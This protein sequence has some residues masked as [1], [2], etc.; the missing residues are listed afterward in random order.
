MMDVPLREAE[1]GTEG[2]NLIRKNGR[3]FI[4]SRGASAYFQHLGITAQV[5]DSVM[6]TLRQSSIGITSGPV[7]GRQNLPERTGWLQIKGMKPL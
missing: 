4:W 5:V 1:R 6:R 7:R 3:G 2:P